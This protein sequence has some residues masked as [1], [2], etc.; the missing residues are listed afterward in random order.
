MWRG[1]QRYSG[2][3]LCVEFSK[4]V[5]DVSDGGTYRASCHGAAIGLAPSIILKGCFHGSCS[6]LNSSGS[7]FG[8]QTIPA[9][10]YTESTRHDSPV[11]AFRQTSPPPSAYPRHTVSLAK[12]FT[13]YS[14]PFMPRLDPSQLASLL[15]TAPLG[16]R[17]GI[18]THS[19]AARQD[20][21]RALAES[22]VRRM[23]A[24]QEVDRNQLRLPI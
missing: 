4:L 5:M 8:C 19:D 14:P 21:A 3:L 20:A 11:P 15:L 2:G 9:R 22:V 10:K 18:A 7:L 6:C 1:G 23:E 13:S 12:L 17:I 24:A 16:A